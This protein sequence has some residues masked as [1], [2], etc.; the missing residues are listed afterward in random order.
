MTWW[1]FV[2]AAFAAGAATVVVVHQ[3]LVLAAH[4]LVGTPWIAF[5]T[6]ATRPLGVPAWLSAMAWGGAWVA[7]LAPWWRRGRGVVTSGMARDRRI[8]RLAAIV[9]CA[10]LPTA[11]GAV[12]M[13]RGLTFPP[14]D[15]HPWRAA[16]AALAINGV[17]GWSAAAVLEALR[18]APRR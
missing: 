2:L 4:H 15:D 5:S 13:A 9:S 7:L 16:I 11:V 17:W 3:P 12:L 8:S 1:R 10:V 18:G 6:V 14:L